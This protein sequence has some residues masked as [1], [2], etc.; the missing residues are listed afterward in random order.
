M[1]ST[2]QPAA[3]PVNDP[4]ALEALVSR[5]FVVEDV[6]VGGRQQD[7]MVRFR[8]RLRTEDSIAAYD[9]LSELL[10]PYNITPL[11]RIEEGRQSIRLINGRINPKPS[12][13]WINLLMFVLT[14]LS[15][16]FVGGLSEAQDPL[17]ASPV[18]AMAQI[19][20]S[21]LPFAMA[22]MA[23]LVAHEF[24][25][26]LVGRYHRV[27]VTLP[28]FI[29]LPLPPFGTMGAFINMKEPPKNRRHL[30]D[31]GLAG[32]LAGVIVAIPVLLLGLSLSRLD[33][34]PAVLPPGMGYTLEGNSILYLL[35]KY[36]MFGQALP[37]PASYGDT[38]VWLY[39]LRYFFTGRP[40][41]LGGMDVLLHPV[42][43]AGWGGLLVTSLNL[44]PAGQFD[45]GHVLYVLFGR[46]GMRRIFPFV[47]AGVV[48]LGLFWTGWWLWAALIFFMGRFHAEPL[49]QITEL[50]ERRRWLA[51]FGIVLF[52]L[53]FIPVPMNLIGLN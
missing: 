31:I 24:G 1:D 50:D 11:F 30:L 53:V 20:I 7:Y 14:L 21:G 42:A 27:H 32:P 44:I 25:H 2:S 19:L 16:S 36:L 45:G 22:L 39:W 12:N 13:P 51:I 5:V 34:L 15:V 40:F 8:G 4:L 35:L 18:A 28:Y 29:P 48:V 17:P 43:L 49:D 41:P 6:T 46:K 3:A 26:Y 33:P 47:L 37:S 9:Q 10:K 23:I 38:P 52:I